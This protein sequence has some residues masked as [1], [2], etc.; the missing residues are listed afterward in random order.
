M[1]TS[2]L[3]RCALLASTLFISSQQTTRADDAGTVTFDLFYEALEPLGQWIVVDDYGYAWQPYAATETP[4]WRPYTVGSWANT[5]AGWTWMSEEEFGWAVY[6]YGRWVKLNDIGW[7]W[8]P[9]YE[10]APSWVSWRR[11]N[12]DEYIGWAPLPPEAQYEPDTGFGTWVDDYYDIGP[13]N[14]NF[15]HVS[16]FGC[17]RVRPVLLPC[18]RNPYIVRE[19]INITNICFTNNT[20]VRIFVGGPTLRYLDG[21]CREPVRI[22][23]LDYDDGHALDL[24]RRDPRLGCHQMFRH[25]GDRLIEAAP[26]VQVQSISQFVAPEKVR[27]HV[28]TSFIDRGWKG[29]AA[30]AMQD[31]IRN[32]M[33][34][35][36]EHNPPAKLP[37]K[38]PRPVVIA[39]PSPMRANDDRPMTNKPAVR[40][41]IVSEP[42]SVDDHH[43]GSDH[44]PG[45]HGTVP[46]MP[47]FV[48]RP[49]P[50]DSTPPQTDDHH[51]GSDHKPSNIGGNAPTKPTMVQRPKVIDSDPPTTHRQDNGHPIKPSPMRRDDTGDAQRAAAMEQARQAAAQ[52]EQAQ[53]RDAMAREKAA[54][55][56]AKREAADRAAAA[57]AMRKAQAQQQAFRQQQPRSNPQPQSQQITKPQS[58]GGG[59]GS[60][61]NGRHSD[62]DD[63]KKK[64]H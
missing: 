36:A 49:L 45:N 38:T 10:W 39:K 2:A 27:H 26:R 52:R 41:Q 44:K 54:Q 35:D 4:D 14:Y 57:D 29:Q 24:F 59:G 34:H 21:R 9:G 25:S 30:V 13:V 18:E 53:Q 56:A 7:A 42:P 47:T 62:D 1:N 11:S 28:D 46:P 32:T 37:S 48:L 60:N 3:L 61:N 31:Q 8:V 33:R 22:Y 63:K 17:R 58:N 51:K 16:D 12:D 5:E 64:K 50:I 43:K 19:S 15:V 55:Q 40:P 23:S 20:I 6:H